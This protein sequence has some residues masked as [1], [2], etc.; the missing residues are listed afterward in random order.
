V[1]ALAPHGWEV[2]GLEIASTDATYAWTESAQPTA[3]G[4]DEAR[5]V[6]VFP[7]RVYDEITAAEYRQVLHPLLDDLAP[8]AVAIAGWGSL[9]AAS[10]LSWCRRHDAR[11]IVMSETRHADGRRVWWKELLKS[12]IVRRFDAALVGG[13]SHRDYLVK[14]GLPADKTRL[15]YNVVDNGYFAAEAERWRGKT[16]DCKTQDA[17]EEGVGEKTQDGKTQDAREEGVGEETQDA[18][19]EGDGDRGRGAWGGDGDGGGGDDS[20]RDAPRTAWRE[21]RQPPTAKRETRQPQHASHD[22]RSAIRDPR[23]TI[24]PFFLASNRFI[25]RKNLARLVDAYVRY[26]ESYRLSGSGD[27]GRGG[28]EHLPSPIADLRSPI[29]NLCLLGDGELKGDLIAQCDALGLRVVE[30]APWETGEKVGWDGLGRTLAAPEGEMRLEGK[31]SGDSFASTVTD[32]RS[33]GHAPPDSCSS[34]EH[35]TPLGPSGQARRS[36]PTSLLSPDSCPLTP[37][38]VFF[39]GFRQIDELPRFYAHA[40]AFVHPA[41]EEPWGLVINEAMACGL[42]V[43]SSRNVGAAEE[44]VDEGANGWLFDPANV[45]DITVCLCKIAEMSDGAR[46]AMGAA[47]ARILEERCPT[48]AFGRGLAELLEGMRHEA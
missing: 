30:R 39:P 41:L 42:P 48:A 2:F 36:S 24:H 28:G 44:L 35:L 15:G 25:E 7:G 37:G 9:D 32:R 18:R 33:V 3:K 26:V 29:W 16:Q 4:S 22:P 46:L 31:C 13:K 43:L 34:H 19:E 10:C 27:E 20:G 21:T 5:I 14:L 38:S 40:G 12:R 8:D 17:R 1:E 11:R 23:P 45:A 47:S 6:T